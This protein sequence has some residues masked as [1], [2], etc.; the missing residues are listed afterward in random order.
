MRKLLL[1]ILAVALAGNVTAQSLDFGHVKSAPLPYVGVKSTSL[2]QVK[3]VAQAKNAKQAMAGKKYSTRLQWVGANNLKDVQ[4]NM[5]IEGLSMKR[6]NST[7]Y[8][9]DAPLTWWGYPS[10]GVWGAF[11]FDLL[12][13]G[14]GVEE[15]KGQTDYNVACIIPGTYEKAK[16]DSV[17]FL[18]LGGKK[19]ED[20]TVWV[21]PFS[22]VEE[23]GETYISLPL[24]PNDAAVKAVVPADDINRVTSGKLGY[25]G[26]KLP[27]AFPIPAEGCFVGYAFNGKSDETPIVITYTVGNDGGLL[28]KCT[29]KGLTD[30]MDFSAMGLGDLTVQIGMDVS[31]CDANSASVMADAEQTVMLGAANNYN[32]YIANNGAKEITSIDYI[33]TEDGVAGNEGHLE[34]SQPIA[35]A[36]YAVLPL[37][38]KVFDTDGV[39]TLELTVTKVNGN[40]NIAEDNTAT[41]SIIVLEKAAERVSVVEEMTGTWC[42]WC[43]RGHVA[44]ENMKKTFGDKVITLASHFTGGTNAV[45][46]MNCYL[47]DQNDPFGNYGVVADQVSQYLGGGG[48]PGAIF[49]RM[50]WA[51]P[52]NGMNNQLNDKGTYDYG[53]DD[54]INAMR[55]AIPSEAEL[56][57][58]A[59]WEDDAKTTI[60]V[61][62]STTFNYDRFGE[63][64]YGVGFILSENGMK[65][66]GTSWM[67]LNYYSNSYGNAGAVYFKNADMLSWFDAEVFVPMTYNNVVVQAWRPLGDALFTN[68]EEIV[69]GQTYTST[70]SLPI[71]S[72]IIQDKDM[73]SL[74]AILVNLNSLGIVNAAQVHLGAGAAGIT[75]VQK[76]ANSNVVER[77]NLNGMRMNAPQ[78]GLNIVRLADGRCVK[79]AVK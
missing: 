16:I 22:T 35:A 20:L 56:E 51:D 65:G 25:V 74:T 54:L 34:L 9:A 60:K 58:A 78:K 17:E 71:S 13:Q 44:L 79:V 62:L 70:V 77:Y 59:S 11:G 14:L 72:D 42:G 49:D 52:Y 61:D 47:Y 66:A 7:V 45:D 31:D 68:E 53:G 39:H 33:I 46:P 26:V 57:L 50:I 3:N 19:Y 18:I 2:S 67:Q 6:N 1:G 36:D 15:F 28:M 37:A 38:N 55:L 30:F 5:K 27:V 12:A 10:V 75:D 8:A 73:L 43:P 48:F 64:P 24:T 4:K 41:N 29:Y 63:N 76:D 21:A 32:F 23:E 40:N 69:K